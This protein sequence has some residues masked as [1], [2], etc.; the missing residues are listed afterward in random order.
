MAVPAQVVQWLRRSYPKPTVDPHMLRQE[1]L[2]A[3]FNWILEEYQLQPPNDVDEIIKHVD[4]QLLQS[5]LVDSMVHGTGLPANIPKDR[6][7]TLT[8]PPVLVE[9]TALTDIGVSAFSLQNTRQTRI[10]RADLAGLAEEDGGEDDGPV[11]R[12][13]RGML[14]FEISDGATTL[15]A[16]EYR[17][18]PELEL[19]ET[20]LGYKLLLKNVPIK[21]GIAFL[22]PKNIELKGYLNEDRDARRDKDFV[23]SLRVRM[24]GPNAVQDDSD[25]EQ[26]PPPQNE[27]ALAQPPRAQPPPAQPP[28]PPQPPA[29]ARVNGRAP[30]STGPRSPLRQLSRSPSPGPSRHDDDGPRRRRIPAPPAQTIGPTRV[31]RTTLVQSSY[32]R[33]NGTGASSVASTSTVVGQRL[34]SPTRTVPTMEIDTDEEDPEPAAREPPMGSQLRPIPIEPSTQYFFDDDPMDD[35]RFLEELDGVLE[36]QS[37]TAASQ[38]PTTQN[39]PTSQTQPRARPLQPSISVISI[40]DDEDDKENAPVPTRRVR[41]RTARTFDPDVIDISD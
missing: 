16:I 19:G 38:E 3:C 29:P 12:Y 41:P 26:P 2:D 9:I 33:T 6:N 27:P 31:Q 7:S 23:R 20:P 13:P 5:N 40:D 17:K 18:I 39:A 36:S 22:E 30:P 8:G 37:Q 34:F 15:A 28:Q 11:P 4:A 25:D 10:D 32:F 21:R 1:W 35:P 24:L 14:R